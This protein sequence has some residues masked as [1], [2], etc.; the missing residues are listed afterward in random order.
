LS[1]DDTTF[2][3]IQQIAIEAPKRA[4]FDV[5]NLGE[6]PP[7]RRLSIKL[8]GKANNVGTTLSADQKTLDIRID[9]DTNSSTRSISIGSPLSTTPIPPDRIKK[10][11]ESSGADTTISSTEKTKA[12]Y[13][14][15]IVVDAGHGGKDIGANRD[16][17]WEKDLNLSVALRLRKALEARGLKVY[18]TRETDKFL[19]LSE[20]SDIANS[21]HPDLFV[22]IHQN[23]SVNPSLTGIEVYYYTPYSIPLAESVDD[24]LDAAI[25]ET[26]NRGVRQARFYV[27]HHTVAPSILVEVGYISN[28]WEREQLQSPKRQDATA[29]A[30]AE[31]V[32]KYLQTR[33]K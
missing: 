33:Q 7:H 26:P 11:G 25:T 16:G 15:R 30:I 1:F 2:P 20:I 31:G 17:V 28:D 22:S 29:N 12:P 13:A 5:F 32:V 23:A 9:P 8:E 14:A 18:M 3:W 4:S 21:I 19:E 6:K 10:A 27:I 24:Q